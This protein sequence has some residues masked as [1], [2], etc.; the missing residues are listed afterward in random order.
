MKKLAGQLPV[1]IGLG[2]TALFLWLAVRNVRLA[3]LAQVLSEARWEWI[4]VMAAVAFMDL[5]VRALRW[6]ILL[7]RVGSPGF[8]L[9]LRLE[10]IG[11]GVNNVLF[12]RLGE[13]TRAFLA[14]REIRI[15]LATA[16]ASIAVERALDLAA[17]LV[18]FC[19]AG[20]LAPELV[21]AAVVRGAFMVVLAAVSAL[22][23]LALAEKPLEPGGSWERRLRPWPKVHKLVSQLAAGVAV[24][25][26]MRWGGSC[27]GLSLM[28]WCVDACYYWAGARALGLGW[29]VDYGRSVLILSWAGAGAALPAAP[30]ALGT[31]EALVK[32]VVV[33]FGVSAP[34]ALGFAVFTHMVSYIM[35][36]GLGLAFLYRVG[37]SL[38][39]LKVALNQARAGET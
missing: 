23:L 16:L 37:L 36:T 1:V 12:M 33:R 11:L 4:A 8:W 21:P 34:Q 25:R 26:D 2:L 24:L 30:G 28:L 35:V 9:L 15:P 22:V 17:L 39:E 32:D 5:M 29:A 10:A 20:Y 7:R 14:G 3:E 38:G 27:V 13:L 18:L 19:A 31:F 6:R